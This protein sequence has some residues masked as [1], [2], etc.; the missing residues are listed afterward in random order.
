VGSIERGHSSQMPTFG[1]VSCQS[2]FMQMLWVVDTLRICQ[3]GITFFVAFCLFFKFF[4]FFFQLSLEVRC[5]GPI[6]PPPHNRIVF[7]LE[8]PKTGNSSMQSVIGHSREDEKLKP[9][10]R[11]YIV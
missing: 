6:P 4:F 5:W 1:T 3:L 8:V 2:L 11:G 10:S 9:S 7:L